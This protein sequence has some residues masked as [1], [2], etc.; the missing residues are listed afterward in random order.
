MTRRTAETTRQVPAA[1]QRERVRDIWRLFTSDNWERLL[2]VVRR[3]V[4]GRDPDD[5]V[6]ES[7]LRALL[8]Y[9]TLKSKD[10]A[11]RWLKLTATRLCRSRFRLWKRRAV[12]LEVVQAV[13][14][15]VVD[16]SLESPDAILIQRESE[17][18][19]ARKLDVLGQ[20]LPHLPAE[21][22]RVLKEQ[23]SGQS[24]KEIARA[25]G[26]T[27]N[28]VNNRLHDGRKALKK[29]MTDPVGDWHPSARL[30]AGWCLGKLTEGQSAALDGHLAQTQCR[31]CGHL[32]RSS[33]LRALAQPAESGQRTREQVEGI[34]N[35]AVFALAPLPSPV[36][37]F[38][39]AELPPPFRHRAAHPDN[40]LVVALRETA[41]GELVVDVCSTDAGRVG[42]CVAVELIGRESLAAEVSLAAH[43]EGG[44][45]GRHSFGRFDQ[46]TARLGADCA[47][48]A[49]FRD[50]QGA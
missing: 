23:L 33:W 7:F 31:R 13:N 9:D 46:V 48:V 17:A 45:T 30:L 35:A 18:E 26:V 41:R 19:L 50:G 42:R 24:Y 36:G 2:A 38:A 28:V 1:L 22:Y 20:Q 32:L 5:I 29:R 10:H 14:G 43:E 27:H 25:L 16:P 4:A 12:P 6:Q 21:Q 11:W 34:L 44:C 15:G 37:A 40:S 49:A 3:L 39:G 47:I 8:H